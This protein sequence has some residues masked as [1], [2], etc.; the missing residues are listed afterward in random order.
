[1]SGFDLIETRFDEEAGGNASI[2]EQ[3]NDFLDSITM[4]GDIQST[5]SCQLLPAFRNQCDQV[6]FHAQGDLGHCIVGGHFQIQL[7]SH[8]FPQHGEVAVLNMS[9][10]FPQMHDQA[11]GAGQLDQNRGG[12]GI[13]ISPA[14]RL[15]ECCYVIDI[16]TQ[17]SHYASAIFM[18]DA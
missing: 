3:I 12:Q 16:H 13:G 5:F 8:D 17:S 9:A 2:P 10:V 14:T 4:I 7:G 6:R 18:H 1:M 15:P 11:I